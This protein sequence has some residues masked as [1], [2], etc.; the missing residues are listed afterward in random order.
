[1]ESTT[2]H[3]IVVYFKVQHIQTGGSRKPVRASEEEG[4]GNEMI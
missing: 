2:S 1:M 4:V 3:K